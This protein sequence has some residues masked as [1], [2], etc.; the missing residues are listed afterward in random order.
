MARNNYFKSNKSKLI[1]IL[2]MV[3][4]LKSSVIHIEQLQHSE[5]MLTVYPLLRNIMRQ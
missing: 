5:T 4:I 2:L 1:L 3:G